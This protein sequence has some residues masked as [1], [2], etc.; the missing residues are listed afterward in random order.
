MKGFKGMKYLFL[1][2][3]R[4][5]FFAVLLLCFIAGC[6]RKTPILQMDTPRHITEISEIAEI[7]KKEDKIE[8]PALVEMVFVKGGNFDFHG[9]QVEVEDYYISKYEL[10]DIVGANQDGSWSVRK[11]SQFR[12]T[13]VA[14]IQAY[15]YEALYICNL[16][17]LY[18]GYRPVYYS[19]SDLTDALGYIDIK[20]VPAF[21]YFDI[22]K[23]L[24]NENYTLPDFYI[25]NT[26]NGYR[27]PT[28]VEWEYAARG[29]I[30]SK[31]YIYSGSDIP[32]EVAWFIWDEITGFLPVGLK[33]ENE[34]GLHDMSGNTHEWCI[35]YWSEQPQID[36]A[37]RNGFFF[38]EASKLTEFRVIKGGFNYDPN[39][40]Y[41]ESIV[42]YLRP[43]VRLQMNIYRT[44]YL[45]D[46][47]GGLADTWSALREPAGSGL[48][49]VQKR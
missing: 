24:P 33:K 26:A 22:N 1:N 42:E 31:G 17:S 40:I 20:K 29:G 44:R 47:S 5:I 15:W 30:K 49:L 41:E 39:Y 25:D 48:R 43:D 37:M 13:D 2:R 8:R 38:Y 32:E 34:L 11:T 46:T 7:D 21:I 36:S 6:N 14:P 3:K 28:E 45:D 27:L 9:R 4:L 12:S 18:E 35:D 23:N 19:D 16:L 10:T